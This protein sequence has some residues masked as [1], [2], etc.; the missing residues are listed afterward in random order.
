MNIRAAI[1]YASLL[2]V[3]VLLAWGCGNAVSGFGGDGGDGGGVDAAYD[4]SFTFGDSASDAA[5]CVNLE[6]A[7]PT[8]T[9]TN[10]TTISGTVF[11]PNGTLPLYNIIVYIP[12]SPL[13]PLTQGVT[14]DQ[15]GSI[16][17]GNPISVALTDAKGHFQLQN[18]PAG[19]NIPMVMQ[20][21]KWRRQ[22]TLPTIN[23]CVDNP[24]ADQVN[25]V[26]QLT[27][28]PKKQS[29][30]DMPRIAI[31]TGGCETFACI[32]PKLGIDPSEYAPGPSNATTL[33]KTAFSFYNGA[34]GSGPT[35]SPTAATLWN[36]LAMLK[37]FDLAMFSCECEEPTDANATSYQAVRQYLEAGGRVFSTDFMYVWYKDSSD[38]NLNNPPWSWPGGA[39]SGDDPVTIDTSFPKGQSFGDWMYYVSGIT[40]YKTEVATY[41]PVMNQFPV[42][43]AGGYVFDNIYAI[44]PTYGLEWT[45]SESPA[46]ST[47]HT[48]IV[49]MGM[50]SASPPASQCGKGVHIDFHVDQAY[51]RV[52]STYPA[53]CSNM[54]RE[55]E[56]ATT[57]FFFDIASCIQNDQAPPIIPN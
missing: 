44:N 24:I 47:Q 12:N 8:C 21:G 51:D 31:T 23:P 42:T 52:D 9:G 28:L 53:G 18:A 19:M 40:P 38:H 13:D 17:S 33:P 46:T 50:P 3:P 22:I 26:E 10:T 34:T 54:M 14:C 30:G 20:V 49:T 29:E 6:C 2:T 16:A 35:G 25:G 55:P 43:A 4:V 45:H 36:N 56:L 37:N 5:G 1:V 11:A 39:P 15:C 41:P 48:R 7:R 32:M 27:R 57:F